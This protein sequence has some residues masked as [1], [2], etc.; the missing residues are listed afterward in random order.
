MEAQAYGGG[1]REAEPTGKGWKPAYEGGAR[2]AEPAGRGWRPKPME[3]EPEKL[4]PPG[5]A[6]SPSLWRWSQRS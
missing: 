3:S 2:E 5:K 1:A 6:G 4:S